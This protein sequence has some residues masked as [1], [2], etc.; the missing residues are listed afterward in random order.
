M[1]RN[2]RNTRITTSEIRTARQK[3]YATNQ[4]VEKS[5]SANNSETNS[6]I[7]ANK[8]QSRIAELV[9]FFSQLGSVRWI[10]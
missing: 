5:I 7:I 6:I 9:Y 10:V 3:N 2:E 8:K 4:S 1:L